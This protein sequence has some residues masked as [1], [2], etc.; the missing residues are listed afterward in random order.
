M[1]VA[2]REASIYT[3]VTIAEYYR[4]MGYDVALMADSTSRWG[5]ALREVSGRLEEMPGEEGYPAYLATRLSAFYER[6]G[7]VICL[8]SDGRFGSVTIVGAVSPPGGDF[9]EPITQN[10]LRIAGTFWALDTN[11]AY[12]RHFPSVNWIKSYSLYQDSLEDWFVTSGLVDWKEM[13]EKTMY[14]LQKEVELQEIVQLVGPDALPESEKAILEVTRMIREDF[15]QQSAYHEVDSFCPLEKQY[16]ML[17]VILTFYDRI[18]ALMDKGVT[19]N[20]ILK[21]PVKAEIGR[22]KEREGVE[23]IKE[24]IGE[25]DTLIATIEVER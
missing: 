2:A 11:L 19:L 18:G 23:R 7:R 12:R 4:D 3:G 21:L 14:L 8:G 20:K 25:M 6:A 17:K 24:L 15:L 10:T 5:E 9:S 16:W 22:M 1:P 13:R